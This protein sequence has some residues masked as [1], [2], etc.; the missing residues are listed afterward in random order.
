MIVRVGS[1]VHRQIVVCGVKVEMFVVII[2]EIHCV[3][4]TVADNK[5]LHEAHQRVCISVSTVLL[6]ANNLLNSFQRRNAVTLQFYLNKWKTI[7]KNDDIIPL[8]AISGVDGQLVYNLILI[9]APVAKI[10]Q[11]I[12]EGGAVVAHKSLL[13]AQM[14]GSSEY[15][16]C[17]VF[18]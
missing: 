9:L 8:T 17:D 15:I 5:Q 14:L 1:V 13:F 2:G 7:Y 10:H 18:L 6:V 11:A 16:R 4:S 3:T 12:V